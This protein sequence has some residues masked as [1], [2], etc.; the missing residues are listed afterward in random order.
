[1]DEWLP[2][3]A[4]ADEDPSLPAGCP[5]PDV[6]ALSEFV[7]PT[8]DVVACYRDTPLTFDAEPVAGVADCPVTVE[9]VWLSCPQ[10]FL[11]LVGETRKVGAPSLT[12]AI[13]PVSALSLP[14]NTDV[15]I[16]GH[17]EDPAA[18]TCNETER[19]PLVGGTPEPAADTIERCRRTFV[20]T[21][22]APLD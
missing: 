11:R 16:T 6:E 20:V 5:T 22:V 15:R 14:L 12:V 4:W 18:Q 17:F 9:P 2:A 1:M 8:T 3:S 19:P 21:G 10:T 13:D 7:W